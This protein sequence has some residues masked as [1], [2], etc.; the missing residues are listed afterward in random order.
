M[1]LNPDSLPEMSKP[2]QRSSSISVFDYLEASSHNKTVQDL[3]VVKEDGASD[4]IIPT[5]QQPS[6]SS[7]V[8]QDKPEDKQNK[9]SVVSTDAY[10]ISDT[11]ARLLADDTV[12]FIVLL[13]CDLLIL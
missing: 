3:N 7:E 2:G 10:N 12:S 9:Q 6:S 11:L 8:K 4:C 5:T 13:N 1:C